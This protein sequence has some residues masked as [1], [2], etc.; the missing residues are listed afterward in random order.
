MAYLRDGAMARV[1][2]T[3]RIIARLDGPDPSGNKAFYWDTEQKLSRVV[4]C[5]TTATKSWVVQSDAGGK[6]KRI[7]F[8]DAT[9]LSLADARKRARRM[10]LDLH[11]GIDPRAGT[12]RATTLRQTL[13]SYLEA[14]RGLSERNGAGAAT[15]NSSRLPQEVARATAEGDHP[16]GRGA[17]ARRDRRRGRRARKGH[18]GA[19]A[20]AAMR[21]LRV[22]YN[23]ALERDAPCPPTRSDL[24]DSGS[25]SRDG[26][27]PSST[28]SC[29]CSIAP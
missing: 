20:N 24:G 6:T 26:P 9:L 27:G 18:G 5:G 22:L 12:A 21:G 3:E 4:V 10:L 11:D 15:A 17:A 14:N 23:F 16:R 8:A 29:P 2:L 28:A 25:R 13:Q 1:T 7:A 19:T